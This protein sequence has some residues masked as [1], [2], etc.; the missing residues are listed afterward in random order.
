[1]FSILTEGRVMFS[2]LTG[3]SCSPFSRGGESC[4]PFSTGWGSCSPFSTGVMF[5]KFCSPTQVMGRRVTHSVCAL[6]LV[7]L[8]PRTSTTEPPWLFHKYASGCVDVDSRTHRSLRLELVFVCDHQQSH[9]S[10]KFSG[11]ASGAPKNH[12][13]YY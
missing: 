6:L 13:R 3:G 7:F 8:V 10:A 9:F 12:C 2:I 11:R 1:M 4:S 5:S